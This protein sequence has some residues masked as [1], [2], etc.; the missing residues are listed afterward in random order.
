M[1]SSFMSAPSS[2]ERLPLTREMFSLVLTYHYIMPEFLDFVFPFGKQLYAQDFHFAGFRSDLSLYTPRKSHC[3]P[4][5]GRSG[6]G[7]EIAYSLFSVE[8]IDRKQLI[9]W[10]IR[11]AA[12]YHSF[13]METSKTVWVVIKGNRQLETIVKSATESH[14]SEFGAFTTPAN[15][16]F[17]T[18]NT[19][20]LICEWAAENWRWYIS[21]LEEMLQLVSRRIVAVPME[22]PPIINYDTAGKDS[23]SSPQMTD[24]KLFFRPTKNFSFKTR[25]LL[26]F[27]ARKTDQPRSSNEGIGNPA[28]DLS[29]E[30]IPS[31]S[32]SELQQIQSIKE[33]TTEA[34]LVL[35]TDTSIISDL[36]RLYTSQS[37]E[38][39]FGMLGDMIK[40]YIC[41]FDRKL[42][43]LEHDLALQQSRLNTVI[44]L[45]EDRKDL[46]S[47]S[48]CRRMDLVDDN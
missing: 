38:Y 11:R 21:F 37:V 28:N 14:G 35:Q 17:S 2:R 44:R 18:L 31:F 42:S 26:A 3:I 10:S 12:I 8:K 48:I 9:P 32:Y 40:T 36:R 47:L 33:K 43:G 24:E 5:L 1:A 41:E 39:K 19:H 46:V 45:A 7:F 20:L 6:L 27:S 13:D 23:P 16:M 15:T 30:L 22:N 4:T 29:A 25:K 34:L